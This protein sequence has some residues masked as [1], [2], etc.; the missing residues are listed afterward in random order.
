M[1]VIILGSGIVGLTL[2]NLLAQEPDLQIAILDP[3]PPTLT[4]DAANY[5]IRC[6]AINLA[7]QQIFKQLGV[8]QAIVAQRLGCFKEICVWDQEL[9]NNIRFDAASLGL[10]NL[11]Y[12]IENRVMIN[13]LYTHLLQHKNVTVLHA[14]A[15]ALTVEDSAVHLHVGTQTICAKLLIGA[16][17]ANSWVRT[18]V[19][20]PVYTHDYQHSALVATIETEYPHANIAMQR[21]MPDGPLAFLPLDAPHLCSIVWSSAPDKIQQ[22]MQLQ[23]AEFT[24][25]LSSEFAF[26]LGGLKLHGTRA[27]FPLRMLHATQYVLPHVA[28]LGDAAHVVHPLAG[29]GLNL[30]ILDAAVLAKV[31]LVA[32]Q[33]DLDLG[34]MP[35]L[36]KYERSRKSH[37]VGVLALMTGIKKFFATDNFMVNSM[38]AHGMQLLNHMDPVKNFMMRY[39]MGLGTI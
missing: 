14:A 28:L 26:K 23:A 17:G 10:N 15:D 36:R 3:N 8:W 19:N 5:D 25:Y 29:Q 21:F 18:Q 27:S 20:I 12:I 32:R 24:S 38:R 31:L 1:D 22:L 9:H 7:A 2:A 34:S 33:N 4:W 13:A 37:N 39:A 11:G 30:G 16:D 35:V 6:S